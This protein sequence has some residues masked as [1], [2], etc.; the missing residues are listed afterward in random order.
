MPT[1]VRNA[2]HE[3]A[4][5][6]L[7]QRGFSAGAYGLGLGTDIEIN[8]TAPMKF[9]VIGI[10]ERFALFLV[11]DESDGKVRQQ[12]ITSLGTFEAVIEELVALTG[13]ERGMNHENN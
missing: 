7:E 1:V 9:N 5:A 11:V 4:I 3:G 8:V 6:A 2:T 13:I 12:H 10:H